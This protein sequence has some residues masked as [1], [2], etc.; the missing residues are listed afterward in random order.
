MATLWTANATTVRARGCQMPAPLQCGG[1][2]LQPVTRLFRALYTLAIEDLIHR[3]MRRGFMVSAASLARERR[4]R[5]AFQQAA[6]GQKVQTPTI[7]SRRP[8][9]LATISAE[10]IFAVAYVLGRI[11]EVALAVISLSIRFR[12]MRDPARRTLFLHPE[13][14]VR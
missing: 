7:A 11:L 6:P 12:L 9:K 3:V 13:I 10:I 1:A 8:A 14:Q 2:R 4:R 5:V